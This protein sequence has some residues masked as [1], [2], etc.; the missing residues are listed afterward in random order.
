MRGKSRVVLP[1]GETNS[2][3]VIQRKFDTNAEH[4]QITPISANNSK[5]WTSEMDGPGVKGLMRMP[6][7]TYPR[8]NGWRSR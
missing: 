1:E 7:K 2:Q 4:Q 3:Q 5:L 8:I 6:P